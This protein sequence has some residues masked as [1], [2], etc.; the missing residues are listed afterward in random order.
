GNLGGSEYGVNTRYGGGYSTGAYGDG[1]VIYGSIQ[2][3]S[4]KRTQ[5]SSRTV[6]RGSSGLVSDGGDLGFI[7]QQ[8]FITQQQPGYFVQQRPAEFQ[9]IRTT[10][11][12]SSS[13]SEYGVNT[14]YGG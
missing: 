9:S 2:P 14:R 3:G 6:S 4:G 7:G 10:Q 5:T 12:D 13:G 8:R 11:S 1:G